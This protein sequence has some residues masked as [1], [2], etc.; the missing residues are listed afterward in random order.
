[1]DTTAAAE[2]LKLSGRTRRFALLIDKLSFGFYKR[3]RN[4]LINRG[5]GSQFDQQ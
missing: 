5:T 2:G 3:F 1:M 4:F